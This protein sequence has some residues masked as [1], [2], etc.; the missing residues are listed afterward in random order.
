MAKYYSLYVVLE[1]RRIEPRKIFI[2]R[3]RNFEFIREH[4]MYLMERTFQD[5]PYVDGFLIIITEKGG[6]VVHKEHWVR[7]LYPEPRRKY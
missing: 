5:L 7:S 2:F 6:K 4:A 1:R 3:H